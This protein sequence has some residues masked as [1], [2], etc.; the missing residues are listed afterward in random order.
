MLQPWQTEHFQTRPPA[1]AHNCVNQLFRAR[2]AGPWP[3]KQSTLGDIFSAAAV[4]FRTQRET[5]EAEQ[6]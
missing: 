3:A 5:P 6:Q 4:K 1:A 2:V